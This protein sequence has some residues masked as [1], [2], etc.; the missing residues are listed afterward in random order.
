[1][2][3]RRWSGLALSLLFL[4]GLFDALLAAVHGTFALGLF[5]HLLLSLGLCWSGR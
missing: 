5:H 4:S 2:T 3:R 1:M